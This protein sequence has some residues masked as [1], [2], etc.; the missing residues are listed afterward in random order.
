MYIEDYYPYIKLEENCC[1][2][3]LN[4]IKKGAIL[5]T[6]D[7]GRMVAVKDSDW[8]VY[9]NNNGTV[10]P[11][12]SLEEANAKYIRLDI[13]KDDTETFCKQCK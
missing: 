4:I 5:Y 3:S 8:S 1:L 9:R 10:I 7:K 6:F 2:P 11:M 12:V 13:P